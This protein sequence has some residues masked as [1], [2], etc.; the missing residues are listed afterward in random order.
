MIL[1]KLVAG[2]VMCNA[3]TVIV[4]LRLLFMKK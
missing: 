4:N 2:E 1:D 3:L